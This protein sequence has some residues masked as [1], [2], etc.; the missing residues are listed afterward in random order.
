MVSCNIC[1]RK[2][3]STKALHSHRSSKH[4]I[5]PK[6]HCKQCNLDI[7][8]SSGGGFPTHLLRVHLGKRPY[9]CSLC[10]TRVLPSTIIWHDT[11]FHGGLGKAQV[12]NN[13]HRYETQVKA[14]RKKLIID[15]NSL[16]MSGKKLVTIRK[17]KTVRKFVSPSAQRKGKPKRQKRPAL[18]HHR[19]LDNE[20]PSDSE[21]S[22]TVEKQGK[23]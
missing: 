1:D 11:E 6:W 20:T 16:L 8:S 10:E 7:N 19:H 15:L 23:Q 5:T 13:L 14:L 9:E 22:E 18:S 21:G 17:P 2:F 3:L 12:V 4:G